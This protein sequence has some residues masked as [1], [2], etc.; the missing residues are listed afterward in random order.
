M[1]D[2]VAFEV[3]Q[4]GAPF[5]TECV[6]GMTRACGGESF[7]REHQGKR[8]CVL[9]LPDADKKEAF[10]SALKKK[11][12]SQDFNYQEV[13]FPNNARL[14]GMQI[15]KPVD[16][17]YAVFDEGGYFSNT[18]F[19]FE[20]KF[21]GATF[22]EDARFE[23]TT[24]GAKVDFKSVTFRKEADFNRAKFEAY[25]DFWRCTF[26]GHAEFRYT[27][28]LQTASFWPA[29]FHSTASFTNASFVRANFRA[30]E[31]NGKAVFLWCAF[32]SAEFMQASFSSD[33]DFFDSRFE[34]MANFAGAT[35]DAVA[36]LTQSEFSAEAR[37]AFTTF[38]GEADFSYAV[39]RDF[40]SFSG[41]R[42]S[43]GFG[44]NAAVDFRHARFEIPS[45]VSFHGLTL[46]PH[47]F[48]NLDPREFEFIDVKWIGG[49]T[50]DFIDIE[51]RE[52]KKRE[53]REEKKAA[54]RLEEH[55]KSVE[56]YHDEFEIER[57]ER[58]ETGK[59]A[60]AAKSAEKRTRFYRLLSITC[61]Q[62][63][64][65]SEENHR[66]DQASDFRFWS[67]ELQRKEGWKARGR[68]TIGILHTLYR[69]LS[70]YGEEI[71]RAFLILIA[72]FLFFAYVYTRV[73]FVH[74]SS[75][76]PE[77]MVSTANGAGQPQK[78]TKA[79]VYSLAVITLQRPDPRP[80]TAIAWAAV[81]AETILGPIQAALLILAVRRR[82][83][84]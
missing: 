69:H 76:A 42:G 67:M 22:N 28:F 72:L 79:L 38:N 77:A 66:Y 40:V 24:F 78:P 32:G 48:V 34:G 13:W 17:R 68:L 37:F 2:Q 46:R 52:L 5:T 65:N 55:R 35:F 80:L 6:N 74:P 73:G 30:S 53:E 58:Y 26:S 9:H 18:T 83:M 7:F 82:F 63:A 45:R 50:Q 41:E 12:E 21:E 64:V 31:F 14:G 23:G 44:G 4:E 49:L 57:L 81:L 61:R 29:I 62:L 84:R 1:I 3:I 16:F 11:L 10:D 20:V 39:F 33:A 54:A 59:R 75:T 43:N 70:G 8:Y 25:A 60:E 47:W 27:V 51:I 19:R 71:L 56:Q 15:D 36:R